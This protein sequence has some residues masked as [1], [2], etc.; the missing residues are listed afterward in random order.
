MRES[1]LVFTHRS[2]EFLEK[3]N[4]STSWKLDPARV[5]RCQY[6][7]CVRN[8]N[9]ELAD[10]DFNHKTAFLIAKITNVV[11]ALNL[12]RDESRYMIEFKEYAEILIPDVWKSWRSPV[13]YIGGTP[14]NKAYENGIYDLNI[15]F[16]NLNWKAVPERD[17]DYIQNYFHKENQ[18]YESRESVKTQKNLKK[19]TIQ[20]DYWKSKDGLTIDEAKEEL[21]KF[22]SIKKENIQIILK[23]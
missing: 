1:V 15:D 12:P 2:I 13:I 8:G 16:D 23:G 22:Y 20:E 11:Q 5:R 7:I 3:L 9:S 14:P 19:I 4:G 17:I 21:S 6:L 18:F 10:D